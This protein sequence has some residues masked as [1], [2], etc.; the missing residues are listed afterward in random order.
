MSS[1]AIENRWE[2]VFNDDDEHETVEW[3]C[4]E[5]EKFSITLSDEREKKKDLWKAW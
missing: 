5:E 4:E 1:D 2:Q 3:C